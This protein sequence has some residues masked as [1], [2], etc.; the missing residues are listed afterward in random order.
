[1][2]VEQMKGTY[3]DDGLLNKD[4]LMRCLAAIVA[5]EED[6]IVEISEKELVKVNP[7]FL[8]FNWGA[9]VDGIKMRYRAGDD[10]TW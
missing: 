7:D 8:W 1:M 10:G 9:E 3:D 5:S 2:G 4:F 6:E